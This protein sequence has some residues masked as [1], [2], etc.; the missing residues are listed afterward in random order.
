MAHPLRRRIEA[1]EARVGGKRAHRVVTVSGG[2]QSPDEVRAF[3]RAN[4]ISDDTDYVFLAI[5]SAD[6][7][8]GIVED[9]RPLSLHKR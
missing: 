6:A 4:G 2:G 8:G 1:L 7:G 5:V 3:L 9:Y